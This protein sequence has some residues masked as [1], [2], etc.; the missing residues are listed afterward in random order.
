MTRAQRAGHYDLVRSS[1][2]PTGLSFHSF[3]KRLKDHKAISLTNNAGLNKYLTQ[4]LPVPLT[5]RFCQSCH[6]D[7]LPL[8]PEGS[9]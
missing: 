4:Q 9:A 3:L 5:G 8:Q 1:C 7:L 6:L 2:H